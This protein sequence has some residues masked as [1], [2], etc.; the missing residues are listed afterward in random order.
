M[1]RAISGSLTDTFCGVGEV[2]GGASNIEGGFELS[3]SGTK[4]SDRGELA[5]SVQQ[6]VK[7]SS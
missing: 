2:T 7:H 5:C 6:T 1:L 3:L 4:I